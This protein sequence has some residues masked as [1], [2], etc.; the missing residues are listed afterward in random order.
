MYRVGVDTGG[1]FTDGVLFDEEGNIRIF[2]APTTPEDFSLGVMNC[3]RE[4]ATGMGLN[5]QEFLGKVDV[6]AHGT[7]V[8]TNAVLTS[9]GAKVGTIS[10][11]GFRDVLEIRRGITPEPY[12]RKG[13]P[14]KPFAPRYLRQEVDERTLYNGEIITPLNEGDVR[15]AAKKFKEEGVEAIAVSLLFSYLNPAHEKRIAEIKGS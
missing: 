10:T 4:A 11:K 7:T 15:K 5:L 12:G 13:G 6:I 2:K 1:T 14:V 9:T 8:T 3:L